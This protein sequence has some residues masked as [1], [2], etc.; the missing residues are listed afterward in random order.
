[1]TADPSFAPYDTCVAGG[2]AE[3]A[4]SNLT[5]ALNAFEAAAFIADTADQQAT[6]LNLKAIALSLLGR[7][8]MSQDTSNEA[9]QYASNNPT[10]AGKIKRDEGM[11]LLRYASTRIFPR[12][13]VSA[14][15]AM[16][17]KESIKLLSFDGDNLE[18]AVSHGYMGRQMLVIGKQARARQYMRQAD[19]IIRLGDNRDYELNNLMWL[20]RADPLHR[21]TLRSRII[22]LIEQTGQTRRN[23]ELRL[24][25]LGG[26]TLYRIVESNS[27]LRKLLTRLR[28]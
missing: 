14:E 24:I 21:Q 18:L 5:S 8:A 16:L 25:M 27:W 12:V 19:A 9:L 11:S 15:V 22:R 13:H 6:A 26:N 1:M 23:D 7:Y 17:L 3:L 4:T 2:E 28:K 10:L 20:I